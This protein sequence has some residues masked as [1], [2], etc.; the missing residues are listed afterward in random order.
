MQNTEMSKQLVVCSN[1]TTPNSGSL[2]FVA[3]TLS[4]LLKDQLK[5]DRLGKTSQYN[6]GETYLSPPEFSKAR[7]DLNECFGICAWF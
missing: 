7:V 2:V 6:E 4:V 1:K 5:G 3:P